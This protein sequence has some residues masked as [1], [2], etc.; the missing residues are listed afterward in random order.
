MLT[1]LPVAMATAGASAIIN[2]WL[3]MRVGQVRGK[4]NVWVGDG[5]DNRVIARMRAHANFVEYAPIVLILIALI[6][7]ARGTELW[8]WIVACLFIIA[9]V[10]HPFGMDGWKI[11]RM[12]GAIVTALITVG[13]G[14]FA[15]IQPYM[16]GKMPF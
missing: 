15:A 3:A 9:R 5:G 11:G 8:L 12:V 4:A 6:E 2:F 13:L 16:T 14:I 1:L 10:L 7:L